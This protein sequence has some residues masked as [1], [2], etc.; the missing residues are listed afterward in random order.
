[1][2]ADGKIYLQSEDGFGIVIKA[3]TKYELVSTNSLGAR[4]LASYGVDGNDL[5]IRTADQLYRITSE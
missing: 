2:Y 1:M 3:S 5:L 4:T